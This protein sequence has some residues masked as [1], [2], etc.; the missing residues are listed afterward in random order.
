VGTGTTDAGGY[1]SIAVSTPGAYTVTASASGYQP[2]SL[3]NVEVHA[4]GGTALP[5]R[6]AP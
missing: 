5:I 6:L 1:Y 3:A 2:A 4:D